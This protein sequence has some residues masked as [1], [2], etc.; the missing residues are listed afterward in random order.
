MGGAYIAYFAKCATLEHRTHSVMGSGIPA[1]AYDEGEVVV[2]FTSAEP[3]N[4]TK[5][6]PNQAVWRLF[7]IPA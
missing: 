5:N 7:T 6:R 3:V 4:V 1:L 2:L